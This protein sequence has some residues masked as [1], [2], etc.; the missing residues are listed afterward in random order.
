MRTLALLE[1]RS[2]LEFRRGL[3]PAWDR[4]AREA[5]RHQARGKPEHPHALG[6][7]QARV[8][9][10]G[11]ATT[12]R[13]CRPVAHLVGRSRLAGCG[14]CAHGPSRR[15]GLR[16]PRHYAWLPTLPF[17]GFAPCSG[18]HTRRT[19]STSSKHCRNDLRTIFEA[20]DAPLAV[21]ELVLRRRPRRSGVGWH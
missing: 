19:R 17:P 6:V 3:G 13:L 18:S 8:L 5:C 16:L 11:T 15:G 10:A 2:S 1:L 7:L 14:P 4:T 12:P 20:R 21:S 9:L